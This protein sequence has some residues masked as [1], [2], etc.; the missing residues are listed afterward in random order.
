MPTVV[1]YETFTYVAEHGF[2]L[3]IITKLS[4]V[5]NAIFFAFS[6]SL[7]KLT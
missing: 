3:N 5:N 4:K 2:I 1:V 7:V 6:V